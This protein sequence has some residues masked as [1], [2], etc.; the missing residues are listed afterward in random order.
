MRHLLITGTIIPVTGI[1]GGPDSTDK[2]TVR[3]L[4]GVIN[5]VGCGY[6]SGI[7]GGHGDT[8]V[9]EVEIGGGAQVTAKAA[10]A[11]A[12]SVQA[13]PSAQAAVQKAKLVKSW[14]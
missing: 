7:G 14:M 6:G 2:S 12:V 4:G 11:V 3:I 9:A 10:R 13:R 1:G 8:Q 5:A